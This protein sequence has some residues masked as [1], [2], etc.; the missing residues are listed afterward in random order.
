MII[1]N[2]RSCCLVL[3]ASYVN[4]N[5]S[6]NSKKKFIFL[7]SGISLAIEKIASFY[8]N[9]DIPLYVITDNANQLPNFQAFKYCNF[10]KISKN[11]SVFETLDSAIYELD[12]LNYENVIINPIQVI[13]SKKLNNNSISLSLSKFRKGNWSAVDIK[14]ERI[15]FLYRDEKKN[16]GK[17]S[18]AFTGRINAK[19]SD[20]KNFLPFSKDLKSN[21]LGYLAFYLFNQFQ[22][23]FDHEVW[24]D[25]THDILLA[26]TKL[27]NINCRN[28]H[29]IQYCTK[30]NS[31]R[32]LSSDKNSQVN[33]I[34]YY[35]SIE[36]NIKRF[37]PTLIKN[38]FNKRFDNSYTIEYIPFPSLGELFLH[39]PLDFHIW[40]RLIIQL[41]YIFDEIYPLASSRGI[42]SC[43]S[44]FSEKLIQR[45]ESLIELFEKNKYSFLKEIY[46]KPYKVN[47]KEMPSLKSTFEKLFE[48]LKAFDQNSEVWFG[49]GDLCFNNIL[50]DPYSLTIKLIDPKASNTLGNGYFGCVPRNYDLA[51]LNH[52]FI[53]LYDSIISNMYSLKIIERNVFN[54]EVFIPHKYDFIKNIFLDVFFEDNNQLL[55]DIRSITS[56]LFL[57]M[58]P[59]HSEDPKRMLALAIIGNLIFE[60]Y[61]S[62]SIEIS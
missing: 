28:F 20:I 43:E 8:R 38:K 40:E 2:K 21:D 35:D 25:L 49:H 14:K 45:K 13:P 59:L 51:K 30:T 15:D 24:L 48:I 27:K 56:S 47:S 18:Y 10:I 26:E 37:F 29:E 4:C 23:Q 17:L 11:K 12:K 54:L 32:K 22:Y 7:N 62:F 53:G 19:I 52:S 6:K 33:V 60:S 1:E 41:K 55:Y 16:E 57:S 46:L 61:E 50:I 39:E 34:N 42:V 9:L 5:Y 3:A 58:L 31:I 36:N 44:F